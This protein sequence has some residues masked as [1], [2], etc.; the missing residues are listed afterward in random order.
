MRRAE[1]KK[2]GYVI[3]PIS[4]PAGVPPEEALKDNQRYKVVWDVLQALRSHDDR[5]NADVNQI[6]LNKQRPDKIQIIGVGGGNEQAAHDDKSRTSQQLVLS[7]PEIEA[8][9]DA[10]YA[11]IVVKCGDRRYWED[12]AKDVAKI[13]ERHIARI[14]ALIESDNFSSLTPSPSPT[15]GEGEMRP[16]KLAFERFLAG[17]QENINPAINAA[18]AIEM[19]S[20]HLITRPV[21]DAL[22]ENYA[23]AQHNPVSLAMQEV[24]DV[25]EANALEKEVEILQGFYASI[26]Q[27]VKGIDN[28]EG[29]QKVVI[30]L[31]DK[32]FKLA[33][34]KMSERLGIVYTPVEVVDF[35]IKSTEDALRDHFGVGLTDRNVHIID[36]FTGTGTFIARLLQSGLIQPKDLERKYKEELHANEIVLLAYYIAAINIEETY[37]GLKGGAYQ[38]FNGIVLTD[39][40]Q[41]VES[42]KGK[43]FGGVHSQKAVMLPSC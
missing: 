38:P 6:E 43:G 26:R 10:I 5:F 37:H 24:L 2:Y 9:K 17:L 28:A 36:P 40:F 42:D 25:L 30:D 4:V 31:Y 23:F 19:L 35:I 16:A 20:Q 34:P 29:R 22:F 32:F 41:L 39:T 8:W 13:A 15:R 11:K 27:R 3:L 33:F 21:F 7:F 18:E 14:Q 12:W 1:G